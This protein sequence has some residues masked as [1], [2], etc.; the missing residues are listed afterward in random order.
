MEKDTH[1]TD[2]IFRVD[3]TKD[4]KGTVFALLPHEVC[5][6]DGNVTTYQHIGQ[7]SAATYNHCI[8]TSRPATETE[9]ADLKAEMESIGY[10]F[11][12]VKKQ[13]YKKWL[14]SYNE[15]RNR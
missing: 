12:V 7:H 15:L 3:T 14:Q 10:N 4:W 13:V 1:I 5:D 11:K 9:Y 2:V 8:A 6:Y